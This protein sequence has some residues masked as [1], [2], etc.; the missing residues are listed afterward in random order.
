[1]YTRVAKPK[2]SLKIA[3]PSGPSTALKSPVAAMSYSRPQLSPAAMSPTAIN[4]ARNVKLTT[5]SGFATLQQPAYSYT[6][7]STAKSILKRHTSSTSASSA[8]KRIQFK[9]EPVVHPITPID[10]P[11]YYGAV[12]VKMSKDERR[13]MRLSSE[14]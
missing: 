5:P 1:M 12:G 6:N 7:S 14:S 11:D 4:T 10:N 3:S 13:W 2:L 8:S 9:G